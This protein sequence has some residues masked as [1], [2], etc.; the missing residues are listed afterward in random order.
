MFSILTLIQDLL[1]QYVYSKFYYNNLYTIVISCG[2]TV[3]IVLSWLFINA[4][5]QAVVVH[6]WI[7]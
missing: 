5:V 7:S 3:Y 6:F 4:Q 2:Y 1:I